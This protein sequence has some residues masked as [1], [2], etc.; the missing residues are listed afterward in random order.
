MSIYR[1]W[2]LRKCFAC[3]TIKAPER[4]KDTACGHAASIFDGTITYFSAI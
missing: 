2:V 4:C 3:L 1:T